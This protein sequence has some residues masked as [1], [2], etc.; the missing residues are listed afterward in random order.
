MGTLLKHEI[1]PMRAVCKHC[2][3]TQERC[4]DGYLCGKCNCNECT[5]YRHCSGNPPRC[6]ECWTEIARRAQEVVKLSLQR[7]REE[8]IA[9]YFVTNDKWYFKFPRGS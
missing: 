2:G 1:D 3:Q 7:T 9:K 5:L 6:D 4:E 8:L